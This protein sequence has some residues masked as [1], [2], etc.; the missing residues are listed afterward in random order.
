[1]GAAKSLWTGNLNQGADSA[2][3]LV[4]AEQVREIFRRPDLVGRGLEADYP[5]PARRAL[6]KIGD[7]GKLPAQNR[8]LGIKRIGEAYVMSWNY[9]SVSWV[10]ANFS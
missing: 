1:M 9:I 8:P 7:L 3:E 2:K 6:A 4:K 10:N 5:S